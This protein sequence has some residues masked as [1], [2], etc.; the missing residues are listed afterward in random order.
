VRLLACLT[1]VKNNEI[2]IM[3][4]RLD[5]TFTSSVYDALSLYRD[6]LGVTS[7]NLAISAPPLDKTRESWQ[8]FPV[9]ARMVDRGN[10]NNRSSD[11][12]SLELFAANAVGSDPFKLAQKFDI[13]L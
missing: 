6:T 8:G 1:P 7:F 13:L 2:V 11:I 12:G 9:M 4:D 5:R 10:L 3:S